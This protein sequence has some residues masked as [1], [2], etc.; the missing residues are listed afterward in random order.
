MKWNEIS[1][2]L[3]FALRC[4]K[5]GNLNELHIEKGLL[6]SRAFVAHRDL[7]PAIAGSAVSSASIGKGFS[8]SLCSDTGNV[9]KCG[10]VPEV[11]VKN[12][13]FSL[14]LNSHRRGKPSNPSRKE[15]YDQP[16]VVLEW[17]GTS[18]ES[19]L[20]ASPSMAAL[21]HVLEELQNTFIHEALGLKLDSAPPTSF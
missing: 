9:F 4:G 17:W 12:T 15:V 5:S 13:F 3:N 19:I 14:P 8:T 20:T 6:L 10:H 21:P 11:E 1:Q 2:Q 18:L 16:Y 7:E